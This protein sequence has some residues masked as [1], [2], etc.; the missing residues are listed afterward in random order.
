MSG[1]DLIAMSPIDMI[2]YLTTTFDLT[3][4][5]SIETIEDMEEAAALLSRFTADYTYLTQLTLLANIK[6]QEARRSG[7]TA[8][9]L[10]D[11]FMREQILDKFADLAKTAYQTT[12]R[13][14][15]IKQQINLEL[16]LTDGA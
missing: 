10:D 5:S 4:P 9:E 1:N 16:R 6:K 11:A 8:R 12:S 2:K 14:L 15:T 7:V 3:T 13:L